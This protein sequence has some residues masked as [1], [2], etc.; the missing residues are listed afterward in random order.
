ML[1]HSN[2]SAIELLELNMERMHQM[3]LW[4]YSFK[5]LAIKTVRCPECMCHFARLYLSIFLKK[6]FKI[7][8]KMSIWKSVYPC[9]AGWTTVE[10]DPVS[11]PHMCSGI[12]VNY[13][14]P[15]GLLSHWTPILPNK[16]ILLEFWA[17]PIVTTFHLS[18]FSNI[19][20]APG[21]TSW[22][23]LGRLLGLSGMSDMH[24]S[25]SNQDQKGVDVFYYCHPSWSFMFSLVWCE[26]TRC[27]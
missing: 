21:L 23:T 14:S 17:S 1:L 5:Y 15:E 27:L 8:P 19:P 6:I 12:A 20:Q 11:H 4:N 2:I 3:K 25:H 9:V 16:I 10:S 24:T 26:G 13:A 7:Q 22:T 18:S